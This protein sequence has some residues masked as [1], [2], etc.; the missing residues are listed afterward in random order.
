MKHNSFNYQFKKKENKGR[1]IIGELY[2]RA[3]VDELEM[4]IRRENNLDTKVKKGNVSFG[5]LVGV[6]ENNISDD[7][8]ERA[9]T[10]ECDISIITYYNLCEEIVWLV[11]DR[12]TKQ[13]RV[14][15]LDYNVAFKWYIITFL[16]LYY[17][18]LVLRRLF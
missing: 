16:F 15:R 13:S 8:I 3:M 6:D 14:F 5:I 11:M 1:D 9:R 12:L 2:G 4:V 7:A 17:V 18:I 10:L